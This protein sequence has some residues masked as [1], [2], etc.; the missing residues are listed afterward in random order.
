MLELT[1]SEYQVL[2]TFY[3]INQIIT[4]NDLLKQTTKLNP[5]T[6]AS[7]IN[8][9]LQKKILEVAEIKSTRTS[10]ARAYKPKIPFAVFM[11]E[12]FGYEQIQLIIKRTVDMIDDP[13]QLNFF[14]LKI[15]EVRKE[16]SR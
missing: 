9:L 16:N 7:T 1:K 6:A 8:S 5:N 15:Y 13:D 4:K 12:M 14:L 10:L 2:L 11:I 3:E